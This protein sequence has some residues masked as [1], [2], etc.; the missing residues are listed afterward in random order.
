MY[1]IEKNQLFF[2]DECASGYVSKVAMLNAVASSTPN[3]VHE[4]V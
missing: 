2:S 1:L 4:L 3:S